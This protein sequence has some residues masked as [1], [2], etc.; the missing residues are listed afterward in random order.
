[1]LDNNNK[2]KTKWWIPGLVIF[3]RVS[4]SIAVPIVLALYIG[5]HLD[6]KYHTAP[7]F[8]LGLTLIAFIIS[9]VT[10]W[11]ILQ[12]YIKNIEKEAENK[13]SLNTEK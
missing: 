12:K 5:K 7:W 11:K 13:K 6:A 4:A 8:F 3:T 9:I 10:I 2:N 1:M